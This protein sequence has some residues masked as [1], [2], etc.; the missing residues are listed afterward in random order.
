M[1]LK[2]RKILSFSDLELHKDEISLCLNVNWN[3]R[4]VFCIKFWTWSGNMLCSN[5]V[6]LCLL[7]KRC[8]VCIQTLFTTSDIIHHTPLVRNMELKARFYI[9]ENLAIL[10]EKKLFDKKISHCFEKEEAMVAITKLFCIFLSF[11]EKRTSCT[12]IQCFFLYQKKF[13]IFLMV[14]KS[15][16]YLH[17]DHYLYWNYGQMWLDLLR[18]V[19]LCRLGVVC[20][21]PVYRMKMQNALW[22]KERKRRF[23]KWDSWHCIC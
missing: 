19:A 21:D 12:M 1:N 16:Y 14:F 9:K 11:Q 7:Y 15:N 5:S 18:W 3:W 22:P 4:F 17:Y 10:D 6:N 23:Q 8:F 13:W 20:M 2:W